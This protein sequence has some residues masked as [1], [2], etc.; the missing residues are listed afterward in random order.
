MQFK[1]VNGLGILLRLSTR[2]SGLQGAAAS[3]FPLAIQAQ[4]KGLK[5]AF[6]VLGR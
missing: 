5:A 2:Y 3:G 4:S 6:S 1:I